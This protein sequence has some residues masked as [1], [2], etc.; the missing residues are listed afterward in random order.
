MPEITPDLLIFYVDFNNLDEHRRVKGRLARVT[1]ARKPKMGERVFL[2]DMEGN[3][4]WARVVDVGP[5]TIR[6]V[7]EE[8]TWTSVDFSP[9]GT[10]ASSSVSWNARTLAVA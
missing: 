4:C 10:P 7:L 9:A 2:Q 1:S 3:A 5:V 8:E 6:F